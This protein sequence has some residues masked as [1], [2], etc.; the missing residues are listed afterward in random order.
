MEN[1]DISPAGARQA[2]RVLGCFNRPVYV[3]VAPLCNAHALSSAHSL[4]HAN[5]C[6]TIRSSCVLMADLAHTGL[7]TRT[8]VVQ[9]QMLEA[10][11]KTTPR[12]V[13]KL[14]IQCCIVQITWYPSLHQVV[15]SCTFGIQTPRR[16]QTQKPAEKRNA[17]PSGSASRYA[18]TRAR[19]RT[20]PGQTP[21]CA[22]PNR[23]SRSLTRS[24]SRRAWSWRSAAASAAGPT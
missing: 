13:Y 3:H 23:S 10:M 20:S 14:A 18:G 4:Y 15:S 12:G 22:A 7:R 8:E 21:L 9:T 24:G 19:S 16:D 11:V 1:Q 5:P 17:H 2:Q 6:S